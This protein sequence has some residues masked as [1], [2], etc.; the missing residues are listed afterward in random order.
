MTHSPDLRFFKGGKWKQPLEYAAL[1]SLDHDLR[2]GVVNLQS[3]RRAPCTAAP[4]GC[5]CELPGLGER[6]SSGSHVRLLRGYGPTHLCHVEEY[7]GQVMEL[8]V[9]VKRRAVAEDIREGGD[10][11]DLAWDLTVEH[12]PGRLC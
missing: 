8:G 9:F 11:A 6:R 10:D 3:C 12:Q 4:G 5:A 2:S 1:A 7:A